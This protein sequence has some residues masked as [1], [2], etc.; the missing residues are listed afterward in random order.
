MHIMNIAM[1]TT[2]PTLHFQP[3]ARCSVILAALAGILALTQPVAAGD[4]AVHEWGTFTSV[5]GADGVLMNWHPL[6]S[7]EL[8]KFV[9]DWSHPGYNRAPAGQMFVSKVGMVTLQR[10]ETPVI[11]FYSD[12]EVTANVSVK[13]PQGMITEWYPQARQIGPAIEK[14]PQLVQTLDNAAHKVGAKPAFTFAFLLPHHAVPDSRIV[15]SDVRVLPAKQHADLASLP[16]SEKS[17]SHYFAARETDAAFLRVN[18]VTPTNT[19]LEHEKFLFYRGAGSFATPLTITM[20]A[21]GSVIAKNNGKEAL[22]NLLLLNAKNGAGAFTSLGRLE[23]G[24]Q[25]ELALPAVPRD[26]GE[27]AVQEGFRTAIFKHFQNALVSAG[28]YANEATAMVNTWKDSWFTDDG[29]RVLYILPR[30]WTD[31]TLPLDISPKPREIVRVMVGRAEI[32]TP[33][34]EDTLREQLT[35]AEAGDTAARAAAVA[36][37]KRLGRFGLPA[38]QRLTGH[39]TDAQFNQLGWTLLQEAAKREPKSP[40]GDLSASVAPSVF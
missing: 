8:P 28:L 21:D 3:A 15:W 16:P 27:A 37:F 7:A 17:G 19:F 23:A 40:P 2:R 5:Q 25:K 33:K 31:A 26:G 13:F 14:P 12:E 4:L 35:K 20:N 38:Y 39:S 18:A 22:V 10:M 36:A 1:K 6:E 24:E 9:Y 11:Y 32:L 30:E 34:L 29:V